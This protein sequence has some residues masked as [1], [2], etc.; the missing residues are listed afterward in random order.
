[1][2][3]PLR[4]LWKWCMQP[5]VAKNVRSSIG[6]KLTIDRG[7][8]SLY[9]MRSVAPPKV[10]DSCLRAHSLVAMF[11]RL[12]K[13]QT[14]RRFTQT[15]FFLLFV[16]A[17]VLDIFRLDLNVGHFCIFGYAWTLGL[18]PLISGT[19]TPTTAAWNIVLRGFLPPLA[20]L[21]VW[22]WIAWRFGR[23][24]CGW[25]CPHFSVVEIINGFMRR[26]SGKASLWDR[27]A[28]ST[29]LPSGREIPIRPR[30]WLAVAC[31]VLA[32]ALLWA[33]V[34]LTYLVTPGEIYTNLMHASLT[35]NQ[36]LFIGVAAVLFALEFTLARHLFCRFGCAVGVFQSLAW[37]ANHRAMV[38]GFKREQAV[39][40]KT[41]FN[42]CEDACPMRLK[43]R[44]IKRSMFTCTQCARCI[45][46]CE[47]V[48][49]AKQASPLLRWVNGQPA[50]REKGRLTAPG[51]E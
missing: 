38:V 27:Q 19:G 47:A 20:L 16:L 1:M 43:P 6:D 12:P 13:R 18:D 40:C 5:M 15:G 14:L 24:Y 34:L 30:Y 21:G 23:M 33:V 36:Q 11:V 25:L 4:R 26:A 22:A 41:C 39:A 37:M 9:G 35:R 48:Q 28:L 7:A 51:G 31:A 2:S 17:P 46:A 10:R 45:S 50:L 29:R 44:T 32:F 3:K 8:T 42:A 49:V